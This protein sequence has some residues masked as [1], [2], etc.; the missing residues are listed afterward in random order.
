MNRVVCLLAVV[1][2]ASLG[3]VTAEVS[4]DAWLGEKPAVDA[5][6]WLEAPDAPR[7][8]ARQAAVMD[9][10]NMAFS[11]RVLV[12]RKGSTVSFPNN[13][14]VYHDVLSD[15]DGQTVSLGA[16]PAGTVQQIRFDRPGLSRIFCQIHPQMAAYVLVVDSPYFAVTDSNGRF[17]MASVPF[18]EYR[19]H[20]WRPGG[21][22]LD[23][24]V[25]VNA[26]TRLEVRWP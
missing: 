3:P 6:I 22:T 17:T 13:D 25:V 4:G 20:A 21:P 23:R 9:L 10:R 16:Y 15:H 8:A 2:A 14:R 24:S 7:A 18:G 26:A 12:I 11:P 5:V 19:Y 1:A